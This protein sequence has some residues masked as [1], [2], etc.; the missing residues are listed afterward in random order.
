MDMSEIVLW[1]ALEESL[2]GLEKLLLLEIAS[3]CGAILTKEK[4]KKGLV[5]NL[6]S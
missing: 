5:L 4:E 6:K 3:P 1:R 2:G